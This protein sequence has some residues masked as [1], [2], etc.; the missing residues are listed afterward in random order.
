MNMAEAIHHERFEDDME[1][2]RPEAGANDLG[3]AYF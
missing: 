2:F 3:T 1:V